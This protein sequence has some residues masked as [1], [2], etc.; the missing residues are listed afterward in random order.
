VAREI[1]SIFAASDRPTKT[2]VEAVI[3]I[4]YRPIGPLESNKLWSHFQSRFP[5]SSS[6]ASSAGSHSQGDEATLRPARLH[7]AKRRA[8]ESERAAAKQRDSSAG[9]RRP[10]AWTGPS[11]SS[12]RSR[13]TA[14]PSGF[15][16]A[17]A[18]VRPVPQPRPRVP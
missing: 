14:R 2:G 3:S 12:S 6:F 5:R 17:P 7:V 9:M 8:A 11:V 4:A 16:K 18:G 10:Q 13:W 15:S 1:P